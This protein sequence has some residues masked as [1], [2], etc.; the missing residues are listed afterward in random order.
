MNGQDHRVKEVGQQHQK[1]VGNNVQH[2]MVHEVG[3]NL[4][5]N[6]RNDDVIE[7]MMSHGQVNQV[8]QQH[9]KYVGNSIQHQMVC[10]VGQNLCV[11][12]HDNIHKKYVICDSLQCHMVRHEVSGGNRRNKVP[13]RFII[14]NDKVD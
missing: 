10:E 3:Q 1:Y 4:C 12:I 14:L 5:A 2:Q 6:N 13:N 8:G 9:E 7:R 11:T